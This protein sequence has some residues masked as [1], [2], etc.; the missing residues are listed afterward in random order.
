MQ[1]QPG[2]QLQ[3]KSCSWSSSISQSVSSLRLSSSPSA[4]LWSVLLLSFRG[5][6]DGE[7][8]HPKEPREG[9]WWSPWHRGIGSCL[10]PATWH[11]S[12]PPTLSKQLRG[13]GTPLMGSQETL[14]RLT[15]LHNPRDCHAALTSGARC[16]SAASCEPTET[17][18]ETSSSIMSVLKQ[19]KSRRASGSAARTSTKQLLR[20]QS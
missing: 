2:L 14:F 11:C 5:S 9:F 12:G 17:H 6:T 7:R 13:R 1:I 20:A 10:S 3:P 15:T 4:S 19:K 8:A 16:F 18:M